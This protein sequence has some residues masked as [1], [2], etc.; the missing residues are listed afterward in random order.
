MISEMFMYN[1][2]TN[3]S[4]SEFAGSH[5]M[6][7]GKIHKYKVWQ[8]PLKYG[9]NGTQMHL[10]LIKFDHGDQLCCIDSMGLLLFTTSRDSR[11]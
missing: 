1:R 11:P 3:S 7:A 2:N 5:G 4:L 9:L 8:P 6:Y 10:E